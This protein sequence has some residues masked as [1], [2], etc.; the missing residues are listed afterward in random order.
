MKNLFEPSV[1]AELRQRLLKLKPDSERQWGKMNAA[2]A[3]A[4]CAAGFE[5]ATGD[6]KP[7]RAL[8]GRLIGGL[9]KPMALGD[10]KPIRKN[11][12]TAKELVVAD[13]RDLSAE[14]QKLSNLI[15]RFTAAGPAG[16]TTHPHPFFGNLTP[17]EWGALMYKHTDHH[18]RQFGA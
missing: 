5:M 2:Q 18:L 6:I 14:R 9:V 3:V 10:D 15:E 17:Q 7:P 4:H 13:Q 12:P 16:C 11:A 8:L 1:S